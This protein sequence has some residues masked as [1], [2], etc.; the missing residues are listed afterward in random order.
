M[1]SKG[2]AVRAHDV[3]PYI[4]CLGED[5]KSAKSAQA[6]RAFHP[7]DLRRQGSELKIG[8]WLVTRCADGPP[9]SLTRRQTTTF[10]STRRSCSPSSAYASRSRGP[11]ALVW[12]NVSVGDVSMMRIGA[13]HVKDS[14]RRGIPA[15]TLA[16]PPKGSSSPSSPK[17]LTRIDSR[18]RIPCRSGVWLARALLHSK[19]SWRIR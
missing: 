5:G 12:L 17:S 19:G 7:D 1:K 15:A 16:R 3:I 11:T 4:L 2:V 18:R 13:D 8:E 14:T 9:R 10:T 6:D